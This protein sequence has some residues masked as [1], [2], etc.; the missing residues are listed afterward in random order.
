MTSDVSVRGAED[1][2]PTSGAAHHRVHRSDY[3]SASRDFATTCARSRQG[4]AGADH[5][6]PRADHQRAR[7][8]GALRATSNLLRLDAKAVRIA[9]AAQPGGYHPWRRRWRPESADHP[10]EREAQVTRFHCGV[11]LG[12]DRWR[13]QRGRQGNQEP[14]M[15]SRTSFRHSSPP[16]PLRRATTN[17][18]SPIAA[19][20]SRADPRSGL[21][22]ARD[23]RGMR[24]YLRAT[25]TSRT[26]DARR[27]AMPRRRA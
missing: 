13:R 20:Q 11:A 26:H 14:R 17:S 16:S 3:T 24:G 8:T 25:A 7:V 6:L 4:L 19:R 9:P 12:T 23:R 10:G 2:L 18:D 15:G 22:A 1:T 27:G 21:S 5:R